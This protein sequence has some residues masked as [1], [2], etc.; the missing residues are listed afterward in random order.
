MSDDAP[1]ELDL[2]LALRMRRRAAIDHAMI[3]SGASGHGPVFANPRASQGRAAPVV[4]AS[5]PGLARNI[6]HANASISVTTVDDDLIR[7]R[8]RFSGA[9]GGLAQ[10]MPGLPVAAL[11]SGAAATSPAPAPRDPA[12]VRAGLARL[13]P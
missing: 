12:R 6:G 2:L 7:K 9:G 5:K 3:A 4:A 8:G 10:A 1:D 13:G 11:A